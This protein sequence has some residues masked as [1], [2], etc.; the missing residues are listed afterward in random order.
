[1]SKWGGTVVAGIRNRVWSDC[2]GSSSVTWS[3]PENILSAAF[4]VGVIK[5]SNTLGCILLLIGAFNF[6]ST[7]CVVW[8]SCSTLGGDLWVRSGC[9]VYLKLVVGAV[10]CLASSSSAA[11]VGSAVV[12][13]L[14]LSASTVVLS[15]VEV[16]VWRSSS[17]AV[18]TL[19]VDSS[20]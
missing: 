19:G 12:S 1:M 10:V 4:L 5:G 2:G 11:M 17:T 13:V 9:G 14:W 6:S 18:V 20:F 16:C 3:K 8:I 7:F 15:S